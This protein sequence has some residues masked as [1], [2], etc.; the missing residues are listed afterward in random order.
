MTKKI[1]LLSLI[2]LLCLIV[3]FAVYLVWSSAHTEIQVLD[4]KGSP[5]GKVDGGSSDG[6]LH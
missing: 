1:N 5:V 3:A 6:G 4:T 2:I